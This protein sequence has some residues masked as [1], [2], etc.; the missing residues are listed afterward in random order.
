MKRVK[1]RNALTNLFS[2][3]FCFSVMNV[4]FT[5]ITEAQ[6]GGTYTVTQSV[7]ASG[8]GQSSTGGNYT[9]DGTS[10]QASAGTLSTSG[11]GNQYA[12]RGGFWTSAP[13]AP[14]AATTSISGKVVDLNNNGIGRVRILVLDTFTG[15]TRSATTSPF[16]FYQIDELEVG[17]FYIVTARSKRFTFTPESFFFNLFE[18]LTEMNFTVLGENSQAQK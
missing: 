13:S 8:G 14:T 3:C 16:G 17:R 15:I 18:E 1:V 4:Y 5:D 10:G 9:V 2:L 6:S 12:M 11:A 7:I